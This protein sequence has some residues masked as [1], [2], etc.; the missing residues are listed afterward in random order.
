MEFAKGHNS[1]KNL[2]GVMVLVLFTSF[3]DAIYLYQGSRNLFQRVLELLSGHNL[4]TDFR[5]HNSV[6][7]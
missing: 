4:H 7:K 1:V 6:K 5:G 3:D 2:G